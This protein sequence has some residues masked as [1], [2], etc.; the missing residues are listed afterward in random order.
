LEAQFLETYLLVLGRIITILPFTLLVTLLV[1]GKRPVGTPVFDFLVIS[2]VGAMVGADIAD[3]RINHLLTGF[4]IAAVAGLQWRISRA[5]VR[6]RRFNQWVHLRA[7]R[8]GPQ[9]PARSR[10]LKRLNYTVDDLLYRLREQ[11]HFNL[12][13][14]ELAVVEPSGKVSALPKAE[15]A[16]PARKDM[17][18]GGGLPGFAT[19]FRAPGRHGDATGN[20]G[21]C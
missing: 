2:T 10:H 8:G 15:H 9:G 13:T 14:L 16:P 18:L 11:E 6:W 5:R 4:A 3:P 19:L 20:P 12:S 21:G 17:G 1:M 7:D